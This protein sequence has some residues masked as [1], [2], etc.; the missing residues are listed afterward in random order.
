MPTVK[1]EVFWHP[2]KDFRIGNYV[3]EAKTRG[4]VDRSEEELI[5]V[6]H[7]FTA[8]TPRDIKFIRGCRS[9]KNGQIQFCDSILQATS[10]TN[11]HNR[12]MTLN[13]ASAA[14]PLAPIN[15]VVTEEVSATG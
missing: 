9:F 8:K 7:V 4:E 12:R 10:L 15:E 5:F 3:K 1:D 2:C 11:A 13:Q 14:E 6:E